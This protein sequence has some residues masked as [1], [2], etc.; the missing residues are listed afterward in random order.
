MNPIDWL[1]LLGTLLFIVVYGAIKTSRS[2]SMEDYLKGDGQMKWWHIGISVM[3]TQASAITFI[4]TTGLAYE[5]GMRFVQFYF[6]LP[7]AMIV[8]S[9]FIVP[10]FFKLNIL[11]AYEYLESRFDLKVR[12]LTASIFLI[13]RGLAAGITIY[14]PS[15]ILATALG[16]DLNLTNVVI[17]ILVI[18]YTVT[19]GAKAVSVT[20]R[21]Q[22][23]V[24]MGGMLVALIII[25]IKLL[26]FISF[27]NAIHVAGKLGKLNFIDFSFDPHNRY[28]IWTGLIGGF[29]LSLSYF[30]TDQSQVG[31]Y[32]GGKSI[33]DIRLGLLFNGIFKIPMQIFILFT[34]VMVFVFYLFVQPPVFYNK[35]ELNSLYK[36]EEFKP[37][38]EK[39][40]REYQVIFEKKSNLVKT[41]STNYE[42][43]ELKNE[44]N[45]LQAAEN[46]IR[47]EVKSL[48]LKHNPN[49]L[50]Q[51]KDYVFILFI[52]DQLPIGV[53][54]LLFAVIF[55][56]AMS[57]T[58][59]ELNALSST[60]MVDF[61][62]RGI[63]KKGSNRH[64]LIMSKIITGM[65]G[66]ISILF[67]TVFSL[68]DN[69]IE[70]VNIIGSLF[71]G[72][73]LG[74]FV[75]GF[76]MKKIQS[77]AVFIAALITQL[78]VLILFW[79]NEMKMIDLPYLWLNLIGCLLVMMISSFIQ[80]FIH[81]ENA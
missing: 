9:A 42:N 79:M 16:L 69:L 7:I 66:F 36:S 62:K 49:A 2:R 6:G 48:A 51:D 18:I 74:V 21:Q 24:M 40:E 64:Y 67:A 13:Q 20:Q 35:T 47:N 29:F 34:G 80:I 8:I 4:S 39:L 26:P 41:F 19:G 3:A 56:A 68:F 15:I 58:S 72:T 75:V 70:A 32:I 53:I 12:W 73:V 77:T 30:G 28:T 31:R 10:I 57:S 55:S 11:T 52:M 27:S 1:V 50:V 45:N 76:F 38:I 22:M 71:Y 44:I 81:K 59:S 37:Q 23:T 5:D 25:I 33:K 17:G 14:A 63:N 61:Y 78:S 65:W 46:K 43:D 60:T 54:G